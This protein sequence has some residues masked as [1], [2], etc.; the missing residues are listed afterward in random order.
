MKAALALYA[1]A[2]IHAKTEILKRLTRKIKRTKSPKKLMKLRAQMVGVFASEDD[3]KQLDAVVK[4]VI[5]ML[6]NNAPAL[7]TLQEEW[8]SRVYGMPPHRKAPASRNRK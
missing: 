5:E 8:N 3:I 2:A 6:L 4:A 7:M 1:E